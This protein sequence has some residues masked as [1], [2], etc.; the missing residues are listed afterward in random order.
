MRTPRRETSVI[1]SSVISAAPG[2]GV[3]DVKVGVTHGGAV[4]LV[5]EVGGPLGQGR[6]PPVERLGLDDNNIVLS[7]LSSRRRIK[8]RA[9]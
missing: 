7:C 1:C 5:R 2:S 6:H 3:E 4:R 9:K 8:E